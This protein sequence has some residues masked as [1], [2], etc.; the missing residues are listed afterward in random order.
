M[1]NPPLR[2][3][4]VGTGRWGQAYIRTLATLS[5]VTLAATYNSS[6]TPSVLDG[7]NLDGLIVATPPF[8]HAALARAALERRIPV[9]IE[10][11]MTLDPMEA[12]T[13][14]ELAERVGLPA[15]VDHTHLFHPAYEGLKAIVDTL[16]GPDAVKAIRAEAGNR[17]PVRSDASVLWD[18]GAHDVAMILE[19]M[20]AK[21]AT[22]RG[23]SEPAGDGERVKLSFDYANGARV[24][25]DLCNGLD[26]RVRSLS[27]DCGEKTVIY[28]DTVPEKL[29]CDSRMISVSPDLPLT[30]VI[31][32]F[33]ESIHSGQ[34][35]RSGL[36]VGLSVVEVLAACEQSIACRKT[37]ML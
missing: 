8:S 37:V 13:L 30:R 32:S 34:A 17:G 23:Y 10:K 3:G 24:E 16:G 7:D 36:D 19:L 28:D 6:F 11:P 29:R 25:I 18:W 33:V 21:P 26:R 5:D 2:I 9:L 35:K 20:N 15:M 12:R 31:L 1:P 22:V 27:V 14:T 4:L